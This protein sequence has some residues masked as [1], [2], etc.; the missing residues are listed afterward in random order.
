[1]LCCGTYRGEAVVSAIAASASELCKGTQ[2]CSN[3]AAANKA[4]WL[5]QSEMLVLHLQH[6]SC[7]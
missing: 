6:D 2:A 1:M 4:T 7:A 3:I 5:F